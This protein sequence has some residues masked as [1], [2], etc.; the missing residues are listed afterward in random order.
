MAETNSPRGLI[1]DLITPLKKNGEIDGRGLG[2]QLDRTLPHVQALLLASP[3]MGEGKTLTP[4]QRGELLEKVLVVVRGKIPVLVWIS[5][6]TEEKTIETLLLL[7]KKVENRNYDG[8]VFWLDTPLYYHSN[9]GLPA[10]YRDIFTK[11]KRPVLIHNDPELIKELSVP[12]KRTNIR[13]GI[14]KELSSIETIKGLVYY[15]SLDRAN[16]YQKAVRARMN[17]RIYDGDESRFLSYPSLSG[18]VSAG[19][20]LVPKAWSKITAS[21]INRNDGGNTYP[22]HQRQIWEMGNYLRNL[23]EAYQSMAVPLIKQTL[24]DMEIIESPTCSFKAQ[25]VGS[26]ANTLRALMVGFGDWE[27]KNPGPEGPALG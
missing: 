6:D 16:H 19:A 27:G 3:F 18:V 20:N 8:P 7:E 15:G 4:S 5:R 26:A 22:D 14:L 23:V 11:P 17:F 21:S 2:R 24:F 10:F 12:L 25:E 9:R 13:T 1:L